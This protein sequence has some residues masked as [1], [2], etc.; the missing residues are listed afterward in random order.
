MCGSANETAVLVVLAVAVC[1]SRNSSKR[2]M[3]RVYLQQPYVQVSRNSEYNELVL[4]L[5]GRTN[6]AKVTNSSSSSAK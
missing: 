5:T 6:N 4:G 1:A 2:C 3:I